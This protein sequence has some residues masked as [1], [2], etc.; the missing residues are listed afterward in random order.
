MRTFR[1]VIDQGANSKTVVICTSVQF[2]SASFLFSG[3]GGSRRRYLWEE[4]DWRHETIGV[5]TGNH[6][7]GL[8]H[9]GWKVR[10]HRLGSIVSLF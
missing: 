8:W 4:D 9:P 5:R 3:L 6:T 2:L 1:K 10:P 7:G